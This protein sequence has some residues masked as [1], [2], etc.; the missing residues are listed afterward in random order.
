MPS[1]LR[2]VLA[3]G[4]VALAGSALAGCGLIADDI[5]D[6]DLSLE[7]KTFTVDTA[8]WG[9]TDADA[10]LSTDCSAAPSVCATAAQAACTEGN[11]FGSCNATTQTCDLRVIVS[12]WEMVI[13]T[14]E[15]PEL[16][17]IDDQPL[18]G[19]TIDS[20]EYAVSENSMNVATPPFTL[21]VAP[22]TIMSPGDPE[23]EP[24]GDIPSV[25]PG[26]LLP[27]TDVEITAAGR[28]SLVDYM[29]SFTTPFNIIVGADITMTAGQPVPSGRL[30]AQVKV[31]A[32]ADA[33]F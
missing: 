2:A 24:V 21:Y 30:T 29:T 32:H 15:Q 10:Y 7:E 6:F 13:L 22:S 8:D 11:C 33:G 17:T 4:L 5:D 25:T 27:F 1:S 16:Q 9:L 14:E 26:T 28:A 23:A 31:A 20:I 18:V 3:T 19:V 12:L